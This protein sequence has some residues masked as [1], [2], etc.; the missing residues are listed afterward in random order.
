M[1]ET[2]AWRQRLRIWLIRRLRSSAAWPVGTADKRTDVDRLDQA[3]R[4]QV[5]VFFATGRNTVYQLRGWLRALEDLDA[6]QGV[7]VVCR[8]SRAAAAIRAESTLDCLTLA[9]PAQLDAILQLSSVKLA[10]YVNHNPINFECLRFPSLVHV[11][12]GH[13]DSDKGV[14][15]SNQVKAYDFCFLAGQ[16]ALDRTASGTM[17]YDAAARSM[18]VGQPELDLAWP[19]PDPDPRRKTV[20]YAPTWEASQP[21]MCYSSLRTMGAQ[22]VEAVRGDHRLIY[23]PHPSTGSLDPAYA[24]LDGQLRR[25]ADRVD[26]DVPL[27][28]SFADA[29][30][31]IA[32]VSAVILS[33]LPSG[34]PVL[35]AEPPVPMLQSRLLDALP[36]LR[37]GADIAAMVRTHMV[38]DPTAQVRGRLV[39]YYFGD[40]TPGAAT[41]RFLRACSD[42]IALRDTEW[43][44]AQARGAV[45]P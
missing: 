44:A 30:L 40:T 15:V 16:G 34:R 43:A 37:P 8:D 12:L 32:D 23:R 33:W 17:L 20:L 7:V 31:L 5:M 29:D 2:R 42:L 6:A 14:S 39:E 41:T 19:A 3:L 13:G 36:R 4:A 35:L 21:S 38:D 25:L 9:T 22:I 28:R 1:I 24:Q 45:G 27:T 10:L 11:Y 26:T 18:L